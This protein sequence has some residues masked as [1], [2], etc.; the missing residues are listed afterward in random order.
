MHNLFTPKLQCQK[1]RCKLEAEK[2]ASSN[3]KA[4]KGKRELD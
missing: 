3:V 4:E 1:F 2:Q